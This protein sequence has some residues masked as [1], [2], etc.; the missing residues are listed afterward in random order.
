L[1]N[2]NSVTVSVLA[3]MMCRKTFTMWSDL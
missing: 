2:A 3:L 1:S